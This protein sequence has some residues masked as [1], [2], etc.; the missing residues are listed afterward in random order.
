MAAVTHHSHSKVGTANAALRGQKNGTS[1]E[2]G[3]AEF[4]ELF[5]D[6]GRPTGGERPAALLEPLPRGKVQRHAGIGYELA[7]NLDVPVLHMVDQL[8][9]VLQ[10]F[11][12]C[13]PV[14]AGRLSTCPR[15]HRTGL[16]SAWVTICVN[17]RRRTSWWKCPR[18]YPVVSLQQQTVE[19]ILDTPAPHGRGDRGGGGGLQGLRP[20]QGSSARTVEQ[21]VDIPVPQSRGGRA[22]HGG[23]QGVSQGT[24]FNSAWWSRS[25]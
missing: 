1:T 6:D 17:R 12:T 18:S 5:S 24:G 22:G 7:Q 16:S 13:L 10:F 3:P 20:G 14:V 8:P 11:A 2:V 4:F 25:P 23:L 19:Q 9:N 21:I 15:S